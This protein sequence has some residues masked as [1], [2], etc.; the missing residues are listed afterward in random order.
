MPVFR[1]LQRRNVFRVAATYVVTAWLLIEIGNTLEETLNLPE[2]A[3][4]LLAFFLIIGFPI[5]LFFSW[6]FEIKLNRALLIVMA[7]ALAYFAA[8]KFLFTGKP[9]A[10]AVQA[11]AG[12]EAPAVQAPTEDPS[13][14]SAVSVPD[15]SIA[16][17]PFVNMSSDPEQ[18]YFSDGLTEELLNL[19]AGIEELKVAARTS[20]FFYKDKLDQITMKEVAQQLEVAHVLEG[21]VRKGGDKI[22]ITA[23]LIK[24]DDGFHLWSETYD[25]TLDDVFAIQDEIAAAVVDQLKITLLGEAPHQRQIDPESYQLA[26]QGRFLVNRRAPGDL[27]L[28][29]ELFERA[30]EQDPDNAIAWI[31]LAPLYV[32][33]FDPPRLEDALM[34]TERALALEPDHPEALARQ[35]MSLYRLGRREQAFPVWQRALEHGQDNVLVL[36]MQA[37]QYMGLGEVEQGLEWHRRAL[38][39]DPLHL[40]NLGNM[41]SYLLGLGR[42]E[43]A[44][45]YIDK[46]KNLSP[47]SPRGPELDAKVALQ[48]NRPEQVVTILEALPAQTSEDIVT[49]FDDPRRPMMIMAQHALGN[50]QEAE[51]LIA[52]Y[53]D[54]ERQRAPNEFEI[55]VAAIYGFM[56]DADRAFECIDRYLEAR[57]NESLQVFLDWRFAAL[58]DDPRWQRVRDLFPDFQGWD[59]VRR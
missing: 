20:S 6:A 35:A 56:G 14:D 8:D 4:T 32:W 59:Q 24:A 57:S 48:R 11:T 22:R 40:V 37:G 34:A 7:V 1:E 47:N 45:P 10:E 2:W 13:E 15:K 19:L 16:V 29:L 5:V 36:S 25:R 30:T 50:R 44:L 53:I 51:R 26:L 9:A 31:G 12:V 17:L 23:Q 18:E 49:S 46:V 38:A 39:A 58:F 55:N 28:A 21:S 33:L 3:D 42:W 27:P 52:E 43:E 54:S 41:A